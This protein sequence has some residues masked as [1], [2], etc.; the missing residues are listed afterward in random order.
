MKNINTK[1][2]WDNRFSSGNWKSTGKQQTREYAKANVNNLTLSSNFNGTLLD[3][4]C[5]LGDAIPIY[6]SAFPAAHL[7][8]VD[9]SES[10]VDKCKKKYGHI[11]D[12]KAATHLEVPCADVIIASH[13][14]EH[15]TDDILIVA[16]LLKKCSD[17]FVFVPYKENPL[18]FEHVNYYES[19]YYEA[20]DGFVDYKIFK[21]Q[22]A[23]IHDFRECVKSVLK[24]KFK[25]KR[26]FS[27]DIIMFH[28]KG[29]ANK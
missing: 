15:I 6:H 20:L 26:Q 2:Y 21:V 13:V 24:L 23:A 28:F 17:L 19:D 12:F 5:A 16:D 22:Y 10:A 1:E 18:Y 4:G 25:F 27:K 9:I 11:A 8:G 7:I 14:M 29:E 3:F